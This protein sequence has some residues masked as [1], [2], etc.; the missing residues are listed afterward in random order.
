ML[1]PFHNLTRADFAKNCSLMTAAG[2][3]DSPAAVE[4]LMRLRA[5]S[6]GNADSP[7]AGQQRTVPAWYKTL[8]RVVGEAP[9]PEIVLST[10][11]QFVRNARQPLN[12]LHLFEQSPR[13][14]DLLARLACGSPFLTRILLADPPALE[15]L[16][17]R[18]RTADIKPR[19]QFHDEAVAAI[20]DQPTLTEKLQTLRRYQRSELL[21]IGVCDAFGLLDLKVVTLQISLLADAMVQICLT[22]ACEQYGIDE[23]P[24]SVLA[25]GKHGGEELNYS[26]DIDLVLIGD[27]ASGVAQKVARAMVDGLG[28]S[29][30]TGFLYRVD[31][32]LR[33]W[34]EAGPLVSTPNAFHTYLLNDAQLWERQALLK[35]RVIAGA[36]EPGRRLLNT[37]APQLFT[38]SAQQVRDSIHDMKQRIEADLQ[39]AGKLISEVKLGAGSIRDIEFYVQSLQLIHGRERPELLSPNTLDALVRLTETGVISAAVYRQLREAYV[40]LRSIEHALQLLHNQQTHLLPSDPQQREWLARRLDY[41]D[42]ETLLRRFDEHRRTVRSV[43]E[44]HFGSNASGGSAIQQH[45]AK[46]SNSSGRAGDD[47][48]AEHLQT[49]SQRSE[50]GSLQSQVDDLFRDIDQGRLVRVVAETQSSGFEGG[51]LAS[52]ADATLG[53]IVCSHDVPGLLSMVCGSLFGEALDIRSGTVRSGTSLG[54]SAADCQ[55]L[56][57]PAG[58]FLAILHVQRIAGRVTSPGRG[59][60]IDELPQRT[61]ATD[62]ASVARRLEAQLAGMLVRQQAGEADGVRADLIE[63]FCDRVRDLAATANPAADVQITVGHAQPNGETVIEI[64]GHDAFGFLFELSN[65]LS[66]CRFRIR[67]AHIETD[68]DSVRDTLHV[69]E[70]DGQPIQEPRRLDELRTAV[71]LIKQFTHWL[72]SNSDPAFALLRF[73]DLLRKLLS[74]SDRPDE[75]ASLRQPR[76][77]RAIG[78]VLGMSRFLWDDFLQVHHADLLPTLA[79]AD[80]LQLPLN[81]DV[82]AAELMQLLRNTSAPE[83]TLNAFKDRHLFRIDL[84]HVLGHCRPFGAF[85]R[86]ITELAEIVVLAAARLAWNELA[87]KHGEPRTSAGTVCEFTLAA[88]GKFGGVEMGFA[89]DIEIVLVFAE[90]CRTAGNTPV[91][92][93]TFFERLMMRINEIIAARRAGIFQIDLR[94]RPYGQAGSAAVQLDEF[95]RYY[96]PDGDA[97]PYERQALVKLRCLPTT[98]DFSRYVGKRCAAAIYSPASFDFDAMRGMREKQTRQLVR[99][100]TVNAKLSDGG[101]VDLEY[102]VQALQL[103]FGESIPELQTPNTLAALAAAKSAQLIFSDDH[104]TALKAYIFLRELIDCLRMVRGN[105]FDLTVPAAGTPDYRHLS[106][107]MEIVHDSQI[108]LDR[109]E[110]QMQSV[111]RFVATVERVCAGK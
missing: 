12:P 81:R 10:L 108:P 48:A 20:A 93:V 109:L 47:E 8:K 24:F 35:A 36:V 28:S 7:S 23:P 56:Q 91:S 15:S 3:A 69:V 21:R 46:V 40:F 53:L 32:R 9:L 16:A 34:G 79:R 68:G 92:A 55:G 6:E 98:D 97:W 60:E 86:E 102:A 99:G 49:A 51:V 44:S 25:L 90:H 27:E 39:R 63:A 1:P 100:G 95:C 52:P 110:E 80:E 82:L 2:F 77:L 45:A 29:L 65:A 72:P 41:P 84:R 17:S 14:L 37:I 43:F 54:N 107:R 103:T 104:D 87:E 62:D 4:C 64:A 42:G 67:V 26:S 30:P 5:Q 66:V 88:L 83:E 78:R 70:L 101:L 85:S 61:T 94:M 71:T 22:L 96:S 111:K 31:L 105:A 18:Q 50:P 59:G 73:R 106:R 58:R 57:I 11:N 38:A 75:V 13:S 89:S 76:V 33:P 19:E 74:D